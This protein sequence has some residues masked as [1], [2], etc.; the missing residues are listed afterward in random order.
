MLDG[1]R[2]LGVL[3]VV[4]ASLVLGGGEARAEGLKLECMSRPGLRLEVQRLERST[5]DTVTLR[6]ELVNDSGK[7]IR[8]D[9]VELGLCNSWQNVWLVDMENKT[10]Y[11]V[12]Y[13]NR[14]GHQF[15][16]SPVPYDIKPG[17]RLALWAR[18]PSPPASVER[19][20]ILMEN[21]E[22]L[23]DVAIQR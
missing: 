9:C 6:A 15:L 13:S 16:S 4:A 14:N 21:F 23:D 5:G 10:E 12:L 20:S 8:L 17:Q 7:V 19:V 2:S 18:F 11:G 3:S 1:C 22:P